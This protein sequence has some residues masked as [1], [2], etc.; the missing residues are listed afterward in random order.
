MVKTTTIYSTKVI[1][2]ADYIY[3]KPSEKMQS[4]V[5]LFCTKLHKS[6]R[7]IKTYIKQAKEYNKTRIEKQEKVRDNVLAKETEEAVKTAILTRNESLEILSKIAKGDS[8]KKI[9]KEIFVTNDGERIRAI[10]Q[11]AKME[12][13][14]APKEVNL[15]NHFFEL[16]V[17]ASLGDN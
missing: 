14:E 5:A 10:Q 1:E 8:V 13:W 15:N 16:M 9:G 6:Q 12:G 17:Q 2:I 7:T 4:V 11:L 3:S